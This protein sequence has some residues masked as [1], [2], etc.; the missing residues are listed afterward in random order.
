MVDFYRANLFHAP[1]FGV[2]ERMDDVVI[3][4]EKG[5]IVA[6]HHRLDPVRAKL[7]E[8]AMIDLRGHGLLLPGFVDLHIHAPQ[9]PQLGQ[10]L[11][12]PLEVWLNHHTFPLEARFDDLDYA[13]RIYHQLV[14]TLLANGTTTAVYF[15][16]IHAA[17][18][19]RLAEICLELG[20]RALVGRVAMDL[21]DTCPAYYR[22]PSADESIA[23]T[24]QFLETVPALSGNSGL[25]KPVITPRFIPSCSDKALTAFGE[26][27]AATGAH[28]QTHCSESDWEHAHV[29]D[30]CAKTD[31]AAL[32]DFGLLTR[33]TIL[34]HA[35]FVT[36]NDMEMIRT[37]GAGVAH[38]PLSN[39]YFS[40]A[41][42]PLRRA[43]EKGV[44]VGLGTDISAG[45]SASLFDA[46]RS[47]IAASRLL[48]DGVDP[49]K[50]AD[51]RGV[52]G[53]RIDFRTAFWMAT[54]GG[55]EILDLP[56]GCFQRGRQFDAILVS[57]PPDSA[58]DGAFTDDEHLQKTVMLASAQNI[59]ASWVAGRL[60][61]G[62]I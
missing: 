43:L 22:D 16:T 18:S 59:K 24:R 54:M 42:F 23:A 36:D 12:V 39:I 38:C 35:N 32:N 50:P 28:I 6:T 45:P 10:A 9:F 20:Q 56:I 49:S 29:L 60:V 3:R 14:K 37:A 62:T 15:A 19:L 31:T 25:V 4:V 1:D 57:L 34:A 21:A 30:R 26:M 11:D 2:I 44:R 40:N 55:A 7:D 51:K 33:K 53:S 47:A 58:L 48:E 61:H 8:H 5:A 27:A 41:V 17:S 52:A 46:A 13:T